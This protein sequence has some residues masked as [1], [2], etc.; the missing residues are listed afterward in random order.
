MIVA[1]AEQQSTFMVTYTYVPGMA[2]RRAPYRQDHLEWLRGLAAAG[3]LLLAGATLDPVDNGIL[4]VRAAD[5]H[6]VRRLL[7]DDPYAHAD[8]ITAVTVR[9]V[10]LVIGG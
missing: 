7:L 1:M 10:G 4:F 9:P 2:E 6:A 3:T 5:R 8:L